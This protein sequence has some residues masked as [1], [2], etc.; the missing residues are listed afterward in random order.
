MY[1][2]TVQDALRKV[3]RRVEDPGNRFLT[4]DEYLEIMDEVAASELFTKARVV[5]EGH[6]R[7]YF[8][9]PVSGMTVL[10]QREHRYDLPEYV[11]AISKVEGVVA[12]GSVQEIHPSELAIRDMMDTASYTWVDSRPG[13]LLFDSI[14]PY[15]SIRLWY[16]RTWAPLH[17]GTCQNGGGAA[18]IR[19][20]TDANTTGRVLQRAGLYGGMDVVLMNDNPVGSQDAKRRIT[21]YG[22]G[23]TR[24]ATVDAAWPGGALS[25]ATQYSLVVPLST[26]ELTRYF[27]E[28]CAEA[29]F[30]EFGE[31]RPMPLLERLRDQ[32]DTAIQ[33]R[34]PPKRVWNFGE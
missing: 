32:Y 13:W 27:I 20:G 21:A 7:T 19:F 9:T 23:S 22:G 17:Y 31:M 26:D 33:E 10:T 29:I 30:S 28:S 5:D 24:E 6:E 25:S 1:P 8:D 11:A 3:K 16:V 14:A 2:L 34:R 4:D 12:D 15:T 18:T